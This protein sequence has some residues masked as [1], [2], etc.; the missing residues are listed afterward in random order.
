M[1]DPIA[2][3]EAFPESAVLTCGC[4]RWEHELFDEV[5]PETIEFPPRECCG[6][7]FRSKIVGRVCEHGCCVDDY[8]PCGVHYGSGH[9]PAGCDCEHA[10]LPYGHGSIGERKKIPTPNGHEYNRRRLAR[11]GRSR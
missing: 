1:T 9:G 3:D 6:A 11:Q 2:M 8:C 4:Q 10:D 7:P 5:C